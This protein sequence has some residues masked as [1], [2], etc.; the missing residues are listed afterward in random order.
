MTG[1][2]ELA[3]FQLWGFPSISS[4]LKVSEFDDEI[5]DARDI[6]TLHPTLRIQSTEATMPARK[7]L[8]QR[9][10][11]AQLEIPRHPR[12]SPPTVQSVLANMPSPLHSVPAHAT[13]LEA[14]QLMAARDVGAIAVMEDNRLI[15]IFSERDCA[16]AS[17]H[18][19]HPPS[20]TPV[21]QVMT[22]CD[23]FAGLA[24]SLPQCLTLMTKNALRYL[25]VLDDGHPVAILSRDLLLAEMV[26][27][28][29]RV[30]HETE[31]D[32]QIVFLRGTYSC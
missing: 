2:P 13:A 21:R 28:L 23:L 5:R 16:R 20:S 19:A 7:V 3:L 6:C 24:D 8:D 30:S 22:P 31:L 26:A 27:Y 29:Q 12:V 11:A 25:P 9:V 17:L 14:L 32:Q 15:G 1:G 4:H 10:A 18:A